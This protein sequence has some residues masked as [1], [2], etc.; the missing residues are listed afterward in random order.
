MQKSGWVEFFPDHPFRPLSRSFVGFQSTSALSFSTVT[1]STISLSLACINT[2]THAQTHTHTHFYTRTH[3]RIFSF[4]LKKRVKGKK[5]FLCQRECARLWKRL[6][7]FYFCVWKRGRERERRCKRRSK[8][9][10]V[11]VLLFVSEKDVKMETGKRTRERVR[12][13]RWILTQSERNIEINTHTD[14]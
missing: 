8:W 4:L 11:Q 7:E 6:G 1:L 13:I 3:S 12:K 2:H 5:I 10:G 14:S 9:V